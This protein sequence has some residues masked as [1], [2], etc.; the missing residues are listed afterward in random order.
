M[1]SIKALNR[2]R[3]NILTQLAKLLSKSLDNLSEF[4]LRT[5]LDTSHDIKKFEDI[6]QAYFEIDCDDE[7]NDVEPMLSKIDG[8]IQEF[9]LVTGSVQNSSNKI[10]CH[11]SVED[12][13]LD[14]TFR[15]FWE[16]EALT[17]KTL[18]DGE[19]KYCMEHFDAMHTRDSNGR[20]IAQIPTIKDKVQLG[21]SKDNAVKRLNSTLIR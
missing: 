18:V 10:S 7:F 6:K 16:T 11:L 13:R 15:L 3:G 14:D 2:K 5:V 8:D 4:E 17:E 20:Y 9:Q 1:S 21:S 19:M 12:T